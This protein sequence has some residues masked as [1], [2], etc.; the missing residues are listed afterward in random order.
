M[1]VIDPIVNNSSFSHFITTLPLED[2]FLLE[3]QISK[4]NSFGNKHMHAARGTQPKAF[5]I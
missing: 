4:A 1:E 2:P 5:Y 3:Q